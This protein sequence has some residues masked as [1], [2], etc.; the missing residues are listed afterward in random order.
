MRGRHPLCA[1]ILA[2][3]LTFLT[4]LP[5]GLAQPVAQPVAPW[6]VALRL[7]APSDAAWRRQAMALLSV[8]LRVRTA[9][10][11]AEGVTPAEVSPGSLFDTPFLVWSGRD[12]ITLDAD[13]RAALGDFLGH[14][15]LLLVDGDPTRDRAFLQ[16]VEEVLETVL[17]T[18]DSPAPALR[19][20]A[21]DD[22]LLRTF[23]LLPGGGVR[24]P[25]DLRAARAGTR[26]AVVESRADLLGALA[27][28]AAPERER[29]TRF[30]VNTVMYALC[31]DYKSDQV[32]APFL[33]RRRAGP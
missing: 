27:T 12:A 7:A 24:S 22:V 33:M 8:A 13:A 21:D 14:G 15:G 10:E 2:G 23:Y 6:E 11:A 31:L 28:G 4:S 3:T 16:S 30:L 20:V 25:G 9:V 1:G 29:A 26:I 18:V 19:P 17:P 5:L 32:H